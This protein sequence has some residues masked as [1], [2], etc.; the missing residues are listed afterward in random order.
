MPCRRCSRRAPSLAIVRTRGERPS[1]QWNPSWV[2]VILTFLRP[3]AAGAVPAPE[4]SL[5]EVRGARPG[6]P[7]G[8]PEAPRRRALRRHPARSR[9]LVVPSLVLEQLHCFLSVSCS[10]WPSSPASC[11]S[12]SSAVAWAGV[13]APSPPPRSW[14]C[15]RRTRHGDL[16]AAG[17]LQHDRRAT[18]ALVGAGAELVAAVR[19]AGRSWRA[20]ASARRRRTRSSSLMSAR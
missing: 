6:R 8:L 13:A 16:V 3:S 10:S 17:V 15:D 11:S 12:S 19:A 9:R 14:S 2:R 1:P 5:A 18:T 7:G 4:H 20:R